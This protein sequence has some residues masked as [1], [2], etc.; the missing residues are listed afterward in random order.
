[1]ASQHVAVASANTMDHDY[2]RTTARQLGLA[3]ELARAADE[4]G[5]RLI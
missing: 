5:E 4:A 1:M 2:L 3:D